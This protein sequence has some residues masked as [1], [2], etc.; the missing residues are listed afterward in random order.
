MP[1]IT[2]RDINDYEDI[3]MA[4]IDAGCNST[5]VAAMSNYEVLKHVISIYNL[6]FLYCYNFGLIFTKFCIHKNK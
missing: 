3:R 2:A 4:L 5:T 1:A 6:F